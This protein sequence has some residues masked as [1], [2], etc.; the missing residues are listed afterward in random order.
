MTLYRRQSQ[1]LLTAA[2]ISIGL[3]LLAGCG[4]TPPEPSNVLLVV[5]KGLRADRVSSQG[6][7]RATTPALDEI[8]ADGVLYENAISATPMGRASQASLLTAR[9]PSEHGVG[10]ATPILDESLDTL[11]ERM[12][13][14]GY[15]TVAVS[16]D[17]DI[18]RG[19]GFEQGF[20][21]FVEVGAADID[22]PDEG[23]AAVETALLD[24]VRSRDPSVPFFAYVVLHNPML[25]FD[26]PEEY[27]SRFVSESTP[28]DLVDRLTRLWI[29]FARRFSM[30][31]AKL[32]S[33]DFKV[34]TDLY[35]G[36]VAYTDYRLGRI[37]SG[38]EKDGVLDDTLLVVTSDTGEDLGDHGLLADSSN[39]FDSMIKVP[40]IAR[41]P[42][43]LPAG[44]RITD[45]VQTVELSDSIMRIIAVENRAPVQIFMP[46][47]QVVVSQAIHDPSA[48]RY[49]SS[50][51]PR[52]DFSIFAREML[53]VRTPDFKYVVTSRGTAA[54]FDLQ[55]DPGEHASIYEMHV[56]KARELDSVLAS[57]AGA[58]RPAPGTGSPV[59]GTQL[60]STQTEESPGAE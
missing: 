29:P 33:A 1:S 14:S 30:G 9:Y 44:A 43:V 23:A 35:D 55:A 45:Q 13:A 6:Y 26:P 59:A 10:Y 20:D 15:A 27:G 57:W 21:T 34:L 41:L 53:G 36:E 42:G 17:P 22:Y 3:C 18:V 47:R 51:N 19:S 2:I 12:K 38:L 40:L 16:S 31:T 25:P 5:I 49:V 11:A 46:G 56:E 37:V 58:L 54:L 48:I 4:Q 39:L 8:A 28:F 32:S 60:D 50:L 24:W 7:E 52:E